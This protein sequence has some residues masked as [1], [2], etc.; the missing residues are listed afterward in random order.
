MAWFIA[1]RVSSM[2]LVLF[3]VSVIVFF[4]YMSLPGGDPAQ[5]LAGKEATPTLVA[6]IRHE[7][8]FD[9]PLYAQYAA[10]MRKT[11]IDRSLV[12]YTS[13]DNVFDHKPA[14]GAF[15]GTTS[16]VVNGSAV[17]GNVTASAVAGSVIAS[18]AVVEA[19]GSSSFG[20]ECAAVPQPANAT[21][22]PKTTL[23]AH[24][25][26]KARP[27]PCE[28]LFIVS[29]PRRFYFKVVLCCAPVPE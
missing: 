17:C 1:R 2:V 18:C 4:A 22:L 7:W 15:A 28:R 5:R 25:E 16:P 24:G 23:F 14:C 6:N 13:Q 19:T 29:S 27:L 12:S 9:K 26:D 8:G 21:K 11:V 3:A 10:M 20:G